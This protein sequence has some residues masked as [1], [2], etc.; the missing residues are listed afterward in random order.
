LRKELPSNA[1][2]QKKR[3][4]VDSMLR[5]ISVLR[6]LKGSLNV[7]ELRD[8]FE[9][10]DN[11]Y[12]VM[13]HLQG[14]ELWHRIGDRH[15]SERT[16]ASFMR[17]VFRTLAQ[18]HSHHIL[19][20][21]IK[22]GNF[23]LLNSDDRSPLKAIDFGLAVP[24]EPDA[25]PRSDLGLEGTP[26]YMAPEVLSSQVTPA[27]D[28]WAAGVMAFQL[29]TGRFPF[30]DRRNPNNPSV[31]AIFKSVLTEKLDFS[32]PYWDG[33]SNEA[34]QLVAACLDKDP[35]KRPTA[36]Q[37]LAHPWLQGTSAERSTGKPIAS[38]VSVRHICS[39]CVACSRH[40]PPKHSCQNDAACCLCDVV[41]RTHLFTL[42]ACTLSM[43]AAH[44]CIVRYCMHCQIIM[45]CY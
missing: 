18:C 45:V 7:V 13:E 26:W 27:A 2:E 43:P 15:Y 5:E 35:A 8:V 40:S 34:K 24:Y 31:S 9:D 28:I 14:G 23:M 30:D 4:H 38:Q 17:A 39:S 21:D 11:I 32:K 36:K 44:L 19:H 42:L 3:S 37:M 29:L 22:P 6:Q 10:D 20:R 12:I 16:V 25:L 41:S 1:S 33:I